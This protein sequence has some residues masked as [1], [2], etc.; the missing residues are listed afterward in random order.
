MGGS[1][2]WANF[3]GQIEITSSKFFSESGHIYL[4]NYLGSSAKVSNF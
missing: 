2:A 4:I 1:K 3:E